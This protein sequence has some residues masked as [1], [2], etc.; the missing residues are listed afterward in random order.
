MDQTEL[1]KTARD[2]LRLSQADVASRAGISAQYGEIERGKFHGHDTTIAKIALALSITPEQ[3]EEVGRDSAADELRGMLPAADQDSG[4]GVYDDVLI[5]R[6]IMNKLTPSEMSW[7]M[8]HA[9]ALK[10]FKTGLSGPPRG[11]LCG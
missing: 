6:T 3:L 11:E 8:D 10:A 9:E 5:L 4:D 1:F 7:L 2:R